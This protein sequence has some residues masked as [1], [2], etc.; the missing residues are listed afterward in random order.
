ML[1]TRIRRDDEGWI[2]VPA[3]AL[4]VISLLIAFALLVAV[5]G[6]R[7]QGQVQRTADA[8]QALAEGVVSAT[9][10][11]LAQWTPANA[12]S[13]EGTPWTMTACTAITGNLGGV[14]TGATELESLVRTAVNGRFNG[15]SGEFVSGAATWNVAEGTSWSTKICPVTSATSSRWDGTNTT[16][17]AAPTAT[18]GSLW[19]LG[20]ST[21]VRTDQRHARRAVVAKVRQSTATFTPPADFALGAGVFT[22]DLTTGLN[23]LLS[24]VTSSNLLGSVTSTL[25]VRSTPLIAPQ[26]NPSTTPKT[27]LIGVRCGLLNSVG[28]S[29]TTCL[30]GTTGGVGSTLNSAGLGQ[31]DTLLGGLSRTQQ[32]GTWTMA[33]ADAIAA[34][35]AEAVASGTYYAS[36]PSANG[37]DIRTG[38][39]PTVG[40][41]VPKCFPDDTGTTYKDKVIYIGQVGTN[42]EGYCAIS[43]ATTAKMIIVEKGAVEIQAPVKAVVYAL[44][45]QENANSRSTEPA[46]E[47]IRIEGIG[48]SVTGQVWADGAGGAV[49]LY[50]NYS[51]VASTSKE[52]LIKAITDTAGICGTYNGGTV[53]N[54]LNSAVSNVLGLV[55]Q[56]LGNVQLGAF[57]QTKY[58]P[59]PSQTGESNPAT[60]CDYLKRVLR[61]YDVPTLETLARSGGSVVV[62]YRQHATR[63]CTGANVLGVVVANCGAWTAWSSD[64]TDSQTVVIPQN[65]PSDTGILSQVLS[66]VNA[67][68]SNY[69]AITYDP[70]VTAA[71][72][73]NLTTGAGP[74]AG[75]FRSVRAG[76]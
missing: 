27:S 28:N 59:I 52:D 43:T 42:G 39:G 36:L 32:L 15:T 10:E 53:I 63:S 5:D 71:A 22:T 72:I 70:T 17:S 47:V 76:V 21:L 75:S 2:L 57:T 74:T 55:G 24:G 68:N 8:S 58:Q 33:P 26:N 56:V 16:L 18:P 38:S 62:P 67:I 44:N 12:V 60:G 45:K 35:K 20:T 11:A 34:W 37:S 66:V 51:N 25:G 4:M 9:S 23:S 6:Q 41:T 40:T 1:R 65:L 3:M 49:G 69:T 73:A 30:T 61:A 50:P 31:L 7:K 29:G 14:T 64:A 46:R 54:G 13:G 19:V 48:G